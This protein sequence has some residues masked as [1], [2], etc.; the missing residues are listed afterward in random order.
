M[1][2][3]KLSQPYLIAMVGIPGSGKSF[4]ADHFAKTFNASIVS[5]EIINSNTIS[6][7]AASE[8]S[9]YVLRELFKSNSTII[10]DK[11]LKRRGDRQELSRLAKQ[12]G[13]ETLFVWVQTDTAAAKSRF[14]KSHKIDKSTAA[15][16]FEN[17][18]RKFTAPNSLEKHIV[19]S[20]KHTYA[21][22]LKI[23]L[24]KLADSRPVID[25]PERQDNA[26]RHEA[27]R[28]IAIR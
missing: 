12:A 17:E 26:P 14:V 20:G 2:P 18:Y 5:G 16:L 3:L 6:Q 11:D 27:S 23:V 1:K 13:Y 22:Q 4:F 7:I 9:S 28:R 8:V 19:I 24:T 10:Y 21:S 25:S 15:D